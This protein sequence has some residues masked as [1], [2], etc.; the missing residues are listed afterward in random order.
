MTAQIK[1]QKKISYTLRIWIIYAVLA[2]ILIPIIIVRIFIYEINSMPSGSMMPSINPG[3]FVLVNKMVYRDAASEKADSA[4]P[5]RGEIITFYPPHL[6][7]TIF[8]QRVI[9]LPGDIIQFSD[10]KLTVNGQLIETRAIDGL[11]FFENLNGYSHMV[12]YE[13]ERSPYRMFSVTV[14]ANHYF[15]MGDN[16]DNSLD[17]REWGFLPATNLIGKVVKIW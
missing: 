6:P 1:T 15:V 16:R 14:P 13:N 4:K 17:S 8:L 9:G 3:D 7:K 11:S 12:Q 5:Q 10:K 2:I